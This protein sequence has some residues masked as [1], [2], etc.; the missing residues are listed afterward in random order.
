MIVFKTCARCGESKSED[1]FH[2]DAVN[3]D[4]L[5]S[6]CAQCRNELNREFY[7]RKQKQILQQDAKYYASNREQILARRREL[8][9]QKKAAKGINHG[10]EECPKKHL[11]EWH[12]SPTGSTSST[13]AD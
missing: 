5:T 12:S 9:R 1:D 10:D 8:Y 2:K 7:A 13:S 3:P 4:G 6:Y 11:A